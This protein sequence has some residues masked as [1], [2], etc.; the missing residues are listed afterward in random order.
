M[1]LDASVHGWVLRYN[2][3]GGNFHLVEPAGGDNGPVTLELSQYNGY[4]APSGSAVTTSW[5]PGTDHLLLCCVALRGGSTEDQYVT[6]VSGNGLTWTKIVSGNDTQNACK[7]QIWYAIGTPTSGAVTLTLFAMPLA[8][9]VQ[10]ISFSGVNVA[11]PIG[12]SNVADTGATDTTPASVSVTTSA[13]DSVVLG[14]LSTRNRSQSLPGGSTFTAILLNQLAGS[15]G[16]VSG[17]GSIYKTSGTSGTVETPT[18][19]ISSGHDWIM[20]A[21]EILT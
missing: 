14:F 20:A 3:A 1:P 16:N 17:S 21:L 2:H 4:N 13:N 18:I 5:N 7:L 12:N 6:A 15:G 19:N 8:M 9:G 11:D 10:L